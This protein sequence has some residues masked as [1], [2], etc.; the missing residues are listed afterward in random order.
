MP[1]GF[2][3]YINSFLWFDFMGGILLNGFG[4]VI[5]FGVLSFT[6]L[7]V[8]YST[9]T[10][11]NQLWPFLKRTIRTYPLE[12]GLFLIPSSFTYILFL[13]PFSLFFWTLFLLYNFFFF[14][15]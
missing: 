15:V 4:Y 3:S 2:I 1:W 14:K 6:F 9:A 11:F 5:P 7:L 8:S 13:F 10:I 12:G